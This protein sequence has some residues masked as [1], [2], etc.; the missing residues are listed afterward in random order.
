MLTNRKAVKLRHHNIKN[1]NIKACFILRK[2]FQRNCT[3]FSLLNIVTASCQIDNYKLS[4]RFF[5][6]GNK[7]FFHTYTS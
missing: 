5:V 3:I 2:L 6:F 7:H 4:D 1:C